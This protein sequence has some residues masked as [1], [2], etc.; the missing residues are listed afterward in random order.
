M[1]GISIRIEVALLVL[2]A[3]LGAST[4]GPRAAAVTV[5]GDQE[6]ER[7]VGSG[8]VL[9]PG[10]VH[11]ETRQ[12]AS[13]C[14]G[15][16]WKVTAPCSSEVAGADAGCRGNVLGCPQGREISR[17]WVA[18]PG[19]DFEPVGLF[20]PSDG[21]VTSVAEAGEQ[22]RGG[23]EHRIPPLQV[24]CAPPRGAVVGIPLH[25]HSLQPTAH[26]RWTDWVAGL[27]V[28]T[29]AQA[30]WDWAFQQNDVNGVRSQQWHHQW[31]EPGQAYPGNGVRQSFSAAGVHQV[32]VSARW[33][34]WFS[35]DG[36]G[37]FPISPELEQRALVTVPTGSALGILRNR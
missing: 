3:F 7:Y 31:G 23:F 18:R 27:R 34:A 21:E 10:T 25:C 24:T 28:D 5:V 12:Y 26:V 9:L 2:A 1:T 30:T 8:A 11:E 32:R 4:A 36:L 6:A 16:R 37:P 33:R 13:R 19:A 14:A 20:C 15:C 29:F 17:A 35:V 22:L